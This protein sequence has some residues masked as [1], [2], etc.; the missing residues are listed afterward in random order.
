MKNKL[1]LWFVK[2]EVLARSISEAMKKQ[3][4]IIEVFEAPKEFQPEDKTNPI[5]YDSKKS[6]KN[7]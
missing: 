6:Q 1:R 2:K 7:K 3:S 4:R 5:G